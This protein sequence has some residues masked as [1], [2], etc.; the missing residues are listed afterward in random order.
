MEFVEKQSNDNCNEI[1][2]KE[3]TKEY[4]EHRIQ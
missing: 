3:L 4:L 1:A 2:K